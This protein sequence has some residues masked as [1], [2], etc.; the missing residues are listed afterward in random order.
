MNETF[1]VRRRYRDL[2]TGACLAVCGLLGCLLWMRLAAAGA[3][4]A[5]F[6]SAFAVGYALIFV[7]L[8][9]HLF[10]C[11][12]HRLRVCRERIVSQGLLTVHEVCLADVTEIKWQADGPGGVVLK[13]NFG[14]LTILFARY[15][16]DASLRILQF[17]RVAIPKSMQQGWNLFCLKIA[18]PLRNPATDIHRLEVL[19]SRAQFDRLASSFFF[20]ALAFAVGNWWLVGFPGDWKITVLPW[21]VIGLVWISVRFL[22]PV[23]CLTKVGWTP[24]AL[25]VDLLVEYCVWGL[26]SLG[27]IL[28]CFAFLVGVPPRRDITIS[29]MVLMTTL[30]WA[31]MSI[32]HWT[33][34]KAERK[35]DL[36]LSEAAVR[37]WELLDHEKSPGLSDPREM[38]SIAEDPRAVD[39]D[40]SRR[41]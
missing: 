39:P 22:V 5:V 25:I 1:S 37:E 31:R 38:G 28:L 36:N 14:Q 24:L 2:V 27:L 7:A 11:W 29:L 16:R 30:E 4:G 23:Q 15:P 21:T 40:Q 19:L 6:Q 10:F 20:A 13:T 18:L 9:A 17:L 34:N 32:K 12:R 26:R 33:K 8:I 3:L 35:D 41:L